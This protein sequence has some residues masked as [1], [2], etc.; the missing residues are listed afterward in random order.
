MT[1]IY[2]LRILGMRRMRLAGHV[3]R[4]GKKEGHTGFWWG[5]L[6]EGDHLGDPGVDGRIILKCIFKTWDGAWT[7]LSWFR[8]GTGGGIL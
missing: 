3:A 4:M 6:R 2:L 8:I 5:V 7:E 1:T